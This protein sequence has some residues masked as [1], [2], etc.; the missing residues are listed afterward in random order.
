MGEAFFRIVNPALLQASDGLSARG[1]SAAPS[2]QIGKGIIANKVASYIFKN[3]GY[4]LI[5]GIVFHGVFLCGFEGFVLP[6][7]SLCRGKKGK[8]AKKKR[9]SEAKESLPLAV[10]GSRPLL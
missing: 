1:I 5:L 8:Q 7:R 2:I 10:K 6:I 9:K 4:G 3:T